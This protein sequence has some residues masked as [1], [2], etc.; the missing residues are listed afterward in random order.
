MR[1]R[2][3][4]DMYK[5]CSQVHRLHLALS[6]ALSALAFSALHFIIEVLFFV[7]EEK[8]LQPYGVAKQ[9]LRAF[10]IDLI[11]FD[12]TETKPEAIFETDFTISFV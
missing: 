6:P 8:L 12:K 1:P 9:H 7:C 3:G 10:L 4:C 2:L 5:S 11:E